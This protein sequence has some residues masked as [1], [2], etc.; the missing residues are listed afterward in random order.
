MSK[1]SPALAAATSTGQP[2][3][4]PLPVSSLSKRLAS[5]ARA[6]DAAPTPI[7]ALAQRDALF[8]F[9]NARL[10]IDHAVNLDDGKVRPLRG[11]PI[12]AFPDPVQLAAY[13]VS[14]RRAELPYILRRTLPNGQSVQLPVAKLRTVEPVQWTWGTAPAPAPA[15]GLAPTADEP[16]P[17]LDAAER[18]PARLLLAGTARVTDVGPGRE[19]VRVVARDVRP[20]QGPEI[21]S[22][23]YGWWPSLE[24]VFHPGQSVRLSV[25]TGP[26]QPASSAAEMERLNAIVVWS[27]TMSRPSADAKREA[28][29]ARDSLD[30]KQDADVLP[31]LRASVGG[32]DCVLCSAALP[33]LPVGTRITIAFSS[34]E[35]RPL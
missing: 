8:L 27:G 24:R 4:N 11:S 30:A 17:L 15:Q 20:S 28:R 5:A 7:S 32:W 2:E 19:L 21:S 33:P 29:D 16:W 22:A 10:Q 34:L 1:P 6:P 25:T 18:A 12:H 26:A 3:P 23:I 13:E 31:A 14:H 9:E 35:K